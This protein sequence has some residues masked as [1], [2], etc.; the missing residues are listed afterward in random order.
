M[1]KTRTATARCL[2]SNDQLPFDDKCA[3][4]GK[5]A[6]KVVYFAKAY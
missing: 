1:S 5:K 2:P 4:C 6:T 3:I